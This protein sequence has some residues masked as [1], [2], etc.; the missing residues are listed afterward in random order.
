MNCLYVRRALLSVLFTLFILGTGSAQSSD[1][2]RPKSFERGLSGKSS[3]K[4]KK[5]KARDPRKVLDAKKKQEAN[6]QKLKKEYAEVV[7]KSQQRAFDIQTPEVQA[8]M[9]Q[10]RKD[11]E[12]RHKERLKKK[13]S[14][15]RKAA[16][17]YR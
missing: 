4:K 2:T 11:T 13:K 1:N 3:G 6:E 12:V 17:K 16:R 5:I 8:R 7:K 10:N 15:S 14:G 9:K